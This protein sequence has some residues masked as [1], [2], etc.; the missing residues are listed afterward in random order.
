MSVYSVNVYPS[1]ITLKT[2]DWYYGAYAFVDASSNCCTDVEWYSSNTSVATVNYTTGYIYARSS[3]T[4]RI[5][6]VSKVDPG[7]SDYITVTVTSGTIY[8]TSVELNRSYVSIEEGETFTLSATVCP[9][10]ASNKSLAWSSSNTS[11]ATVSSSGKVTAKS[12]GYV[13]ITATAKDGSGRRDCCEFLVTGDVLVGSITVSPSY[14]ELTKGESRRLYETVCPTNATNK[15]VRWSSS[16]TNIVFVNPDSGLVYAQ[17]AG[18]STITATATDGSGK[19]GTCTVRVNAPVPVT[20]IEVCPASKT[21]NVGDT[22][23][24]CATVYPYNATDKSVIWCSS[25]ENVAE[26]SMRSG[27]ITAKQAGTATITATTVDGEYCDCCTL[28]VELT[29][30]QL[31]EQIVLCFSLLTEY[32]SY[33]YLSPMQYAVLKELDSEEEAIAEQ[34]ELVQSIQLL[35]YILLEN[36]LVVNSPTASSTIAKHI[37]NGEKYDYFEQSDITADIRNHSDVF[38]E[39]WR[40]R[41]KQSWLELAQLLVVAGTMIPYIQIPASLVLLGQGIVGKDFTGRQL[42]WWERALNIVGGTLATIEGVGFISSAIRNG[43]NVKFIDKLDEIARIAGDHAASELAYA[44]KTGR[45]SGRALNGALDAALINKVK[46]FRGSFID[47]LFNEGNVAVAEVNISGLKSDWFA[48]SRINNI[49]DMKPAGAVSNIS[50]MPADPVFSATEVGGFMR[51]VDAEYKILSDIANTLGNNTS[52]VGTIKI[53]TER[54]PC[55]S[56]AKVIQQ[57]ANKYKNIAIEVVDNSHKLL[58]P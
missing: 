25:N 12:R 21:M 51:T 18:T 44:L 33:A 55:N 47:D 37:L 17:N 10:N 31:S 27:H 28:D 24:L 1:C 26:V 5:Y 52:A 57:F 7:K 34:T 4:A 22:D 16:N 6:A 2:G 56:C 36:K 43:R 50:L 20:G 58:I 23:Y 45:I 9:T 54:P 41:N 35:N 40:E 8:V 29:D 42:I 32:S 39:V 38:D 14:L 48:H 49:S 15:C 30:E 53:L 19:K 13:T 46:N 11:I 3:G